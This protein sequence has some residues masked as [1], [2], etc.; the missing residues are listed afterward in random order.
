MACKIKTSSVPKEVLLLNFARSLRRHYPDQVCGSK[1]IN[2][3][4]SLT[5]QGSPS[6][7]EFIYEYKGLQSGCQVIEKAHETHFTGLDVSTRFL[8]VIL[9]GSLRF[10]E[11]NSSNKRLNFL[12]SSNLGKGP[13][14]SKSIRWMSVWGDDK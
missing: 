1:A 10:V 2:L 14:P 11:K 13:D 9:V 7:C 12:G 6:C 3:P 4:L 5:K 8:I